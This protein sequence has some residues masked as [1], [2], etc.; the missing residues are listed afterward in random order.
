MAAREESEE[1]DVEGDRLLPLPLL[2][3]LLCVWTRG[4]CVLM[5]AEEDEDG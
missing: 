1:R 5:A 2:L 3:L 4:G